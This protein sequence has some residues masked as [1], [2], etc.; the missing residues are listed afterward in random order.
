MKMRPGPT[1]RLGALLVTLFAPLTAGAAE[2]VFLFLQLNGNDVA[3]EPSITQI[4]GEDVSNA[5]ECL[6]FSTLAFEAAPSKGGGNPLYRPIT[7]TKRNNQ[8]SPLLLQGFAQQLPVTAEF[9]FYRRAPGGGADERYQ[10]V[11][12]TQGRISSLS[13]ASPD[14]LSPATAANPPTDVVSFTFTTMT[15]R[16]E[17]TGQEFT[18][19]L[20]P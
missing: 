3:G 7:I 17:L 20:T 19:D 5:I 1:I 11:T 10:T 9:R 16:N 6:S 15:W 4:A 8:S 12:L 2:P 18:V 13:L 14:Q